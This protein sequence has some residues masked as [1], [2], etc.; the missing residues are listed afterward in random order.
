[1]KS[2]FVDKFIDRMDRVD[3]QAV[4]S[5]VLR[6]VQEKGFLEK[7]F[8]ALREGVIVADPEGRIIYINR[9]A[10]DLFGIDRDDS[11]GA[12]VESRIRGLEWSSL[13]GQGKGRV[14]SR[15]LEIFYP[16]NRYLNFY[17]APLESG[18]D[19]IGNGASG[20]AQNG[21]DELGYVLLLRDIT[22]SR[23]VQMEKIESE[24][25]NALTLLAAGVAHEIGNPLNSLN[26]HLQLVERKLKKADPELAKELGD[27]LEISRAEI[28]RLDFIVEKFLSAIRPTQ[29]QTELSNLNGLLQE[30]VRFLAPEIEDRG[31]EVCMELNS[32]MPMIPLDRDQ[33]R[34]AFY[35]LIRN[36]IQAIGQNGRLTMRTDL[37][38]YNII[39]SFTDTGGG[40]SAEAMGNLFQ[41][42]FTTKKAG[43]GLGLLIVR[44]I[45]REHGGEIEF[46]SAEGQGTK[47]TIYLPRVEKRLR[48]LPE[49]SSAS[50]TQGPSA[51]AETGTG[52][53]PVIEVEFTEADQPN[54]KS[55]GRGRG[56][57]K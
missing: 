24:R 33:M 35:N 30:S 39:V 7:V 9:A 42:Y 11:V 20:P 12:S 45:V 44:R 57:K 55:R 17:L 8:D 18:A 34:Q 49:T 1:M 27:L 2:S 3:P 38:D 40:I 51:V 26:I 53:R 36:G 14:V 50:T 28:K 13:V 56:R 48:F 32:Q 19:A 25:M 52:K 41:P 37:D 15:D 23:Q 29:L 5:Y 6:L 21:E 10:C 31:V 54:K 4:Q 46:E 22:Q 47:V 16:E 43:S